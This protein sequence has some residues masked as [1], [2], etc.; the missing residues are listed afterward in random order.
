MIRDLSKLISTL[1]FIGNIP[2]AP[3]TFG[4]LAALIF[5]YILKPND[6]ELLFL[7]IFGSILGVFCSHITEKHLEE[8]DSKKIVIDEFVGY[9]ASLLFLPQTFYN[10]II[11]F[12]LFRFFDIFKPFP[13][14]LLERRIHGGLGIMIDDLVAAVYA[15]LL[16][17]ITHIFL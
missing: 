1:F 16:F 5:V 10:L 8:R 12:F 2:F 11:I 17:R 7:V 13:V 14:R 15:N 3:G 4:S 9:M 6:L